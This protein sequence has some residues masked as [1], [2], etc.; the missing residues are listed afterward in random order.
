VRSYPAA[1]KGNDADDYHGERVADPYRWLETTTDPEV[2]GWIK[3][4]NELTEGFLRAIPDREAIRA[5]VTGLSDYPKLGVPFE[6]GGRW[7]QFR[8][9][10]LAAQPV[11][12]V[13][14]E[15]GADG[16]PLLDPNTLSADGTTAVSSADVSDDGKLLAYATSDGGSDWLTWHVRDVETG[17]DLPDVIEWSKFCNAAWRID[18]SGF[19]YGSM[20]ATA[21][22]AEY[23][24]TNAAPRIMLHRLGT[25]QRDDEL[26]FA[27]PDEPEWM[28]YAEVSDDG[29]FLIVTIEKASVF[30][31][32]VLVSDLE[33][34]RGELRALV[35][36]FESVNQVVTTEG[37]TFY[38]VTDY[39]AERKRLVAV[40]LGQPD[41][42]HWRDVIPEAPETLVSAWFFGGH[43]VCHYL[44]DAQSVLRVHARDGRAVR[45][46]PLPGM[47]ALALDPGLRWAIAGR[48]GSDLIHFSVT[49][50]TE[51]GSIWS[52][53]LA[54]GLTEIVRRAAAPLDPDRYLTEQVFAE[55]ADGTRVP[56]FLTRRRDVQ[57]DGQAPALLYAYGG[58]DIPITP[59]FSAQW[60]AWL[61]RGGVL[62]VANL[63][64]GG[65]YG[66]AWHE[67]GRR[68]AKQHV[69]DDFCAC[70]RW[71]AASGWSN[72]DRI[73]ITGGS[74]GGLLVGACLTQHPELFGACVPHVGVHDMLRFHKFTIGWAWT[75]E[76]GS[77][78]DPV[79]YRWL[80]GYS[81][82]HNVR[83]GQRYPATLL[84]TGDH[85]DRVVPG[86]S[87]KFAAA[88]QAA[89]AGDEP[90]LIRVET[91][92]GH[93]AGKPTDKQIAADT[94]VL[95]FLAAV[96]P[97]RPGP[98]T[99]HDHL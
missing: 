24:E 37:T 87:F 56:V 38:L 49:T 44:R 95:A 40:D 6:R 64:G 92:A 69:F 96:L 27:A 17:A 35:G 12:Y 5:R 43:F 28:P 65:E 63:R 50:F 9:P 97:R 84:L 3:A 18:G 59:E 86:H 89:Q 67:A 79:E 93:G 25:A 42:P 22:G 90:I 82:L 57:P 30:E 80:R 74:N 91:A 26:A 10:G 41:R 33:D 53:R 66:R 14:D 98:D 11:L 20:Q 51:P 70:A 54:A 77:P 52:H 73:A 2:L 45:E 47:A 39:G 32:Q 78:D 88:L 34:T 13:M 31:N 29:R 8:N 61:E 46:I 94:D 7:F 15:P 21:P 55:S 60:A 76:V 83:P 68:A 16:H 71:L 48:R 72:A 85:D 99:A 75:G 62:A 81:P 1:R 23:L 19:F 4:Q 58:F 36:D